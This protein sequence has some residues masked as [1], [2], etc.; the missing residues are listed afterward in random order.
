M[1]NQLSMPCTPVLKYEARISKFEFFRI[2][3]FGFTLSNNSSFHFSKNLPFCVTALYRFAFIEFLFA[4]D[5]R[6]VYLDRSSFIIHRQWHNCQTLAVLESCHGI[7]LFF[8]KEKFT[9]S[10]G[11]VVF[12]RVFRLV[13]WDGRADKEGFATP[14]GDMCGG[15]LTLPCADGLHFKAKKLDTRGKGFEYLIVKSCFLIR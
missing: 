9:V 8:G 5:D 10:L 12:G 7:E 3:C 13:G 6:D 14:H 1:V 4:S 11:V 15:K 2:S